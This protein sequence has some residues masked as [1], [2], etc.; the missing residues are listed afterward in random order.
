MDLLDRSWMYL[1]SLPKGGEEGERNEQRKRDRASWGQR[2]DRAR[3]KCRRA[4]GGSSTPAD[5]DADD[6]TQVSA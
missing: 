5:Y 2:P 4:R 6:C 1:V 3:R